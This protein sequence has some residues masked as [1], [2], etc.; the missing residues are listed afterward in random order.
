MQNS[1]KHTHKYRFSRFE[2][3]DSILH[4]SIKSQQS[5]SELINCRYLNDKNWLFLPKSNEF[6]FV[7]T[8]CQEK[9]RVLEK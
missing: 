5:I 2:Y 8:F 7:F 9:L 3:F 6:H 4:R 1:T